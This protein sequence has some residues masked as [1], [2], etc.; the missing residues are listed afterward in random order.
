METTQT[1]EANEQKIEKVNFF[2]VRTQYGRFKFRLKHFKSGLN[3]M[4]LRS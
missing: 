3:F 2:L 1:V 4:K